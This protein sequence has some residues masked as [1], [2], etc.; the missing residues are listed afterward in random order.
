MDELIIADVNTDVG[1]TGFI[2]LKKHEISSCQMRFGGAAN[3]QPKPAHHPAG[4]LWCYA[5]TVGPAL[6]GAV[7]H[8]GG[9]VELATYADV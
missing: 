6:I 3:W 9:A 7:V 1:R 8:P 2:G 5:Q 4:A